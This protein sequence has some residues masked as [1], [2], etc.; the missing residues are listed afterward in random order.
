MH[1]CMYVYNKSC[2][3]WFEEIIKSYMVI[4]LNQYLKYYKWNDEGI[5]NAMRWKRGFSKHLPLSNFDTSSYDGDEG[6]T[7][8]TLN[9]FYKFWNERALKISIEYLDINLFPK[10]NPK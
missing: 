3:W 8:E 2:K 4:D 7:K 1:V 9:H 6:F 10:T 5:D